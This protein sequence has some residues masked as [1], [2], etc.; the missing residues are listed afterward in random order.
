MRRILGVACVGAATVAAVLCAFGSGLRPNV[1]GEPL[2]LGRLYTLTVDLSE[3][4]FGR[5]WSLSD[6][7]AAAGTGVTQAWATSKGQGAV[8]AVIDTGIVP[9]PDIMGNLLPGYDF[10]SNRVIAND[11]DG[12]D[13]DPSD[14]GDWVSQVESTSLF[15]GACQ[16]S[17]SSW[18]G[19]HVAGIVAA[20]DDNGFGVAGVAPRAKVLPIRAI[21]KCGASEPD[22]LAAITWAS[23]GHVP[24][25]P[26]NP[27][28]ADIINLSLGQASVCKPATQAVITAAISRGSAVVVA[29]GNSGSPVEQSSPAN[30][31]GVLSVGALSRSGALAMYSNYASSPNL[32]FIVAPGGEGSG[33]GGIFSTIN[34]GTTVPVAADFGYMAG[35]SM[36]APHVSGL[37]AILKG[38]SP[39]LRGAQLIVELGKFLK[40]N[41]S[42]SCALF[43]CGAGQPNLASISQLSS[44][45]IGLPTVKRFQERLSLEWPVLPQ[46]LIGERV[47]VQVKQSGGSWGASRL[48]TLPKAD[49]TGLSSEILYTVRVRVIISGNAGPWRELPYEYRLGSR[50][51]APTLVQAVAKD[52]ALSIS[53]SEEKADL[54]VVRIGYLV[55]AT[56]KRNAVSRT[57]STVNLTCEITH[58]T[59]G[60][61]YAV[62][63]KAVTTDGYTA[64]S[65]PIVAIPYTV[66]DRPRRVSISRSLRSAIVTWLPPASDGGSAIVGYVASAIGPDGSQE[67]CETTTQ[68]CHLVT[69]KNGQQADITVN[70][71]NRA[72][73]SPI[74]QLQNAVV[75]PL[76]TTELAFVSGPSVTRVGKQGTRFL[77]WSPKVPDMLF[78]D[79]SIRGHYFC[80]G[81]WVPFGSRK[82]STRRIENVA[83]SPTKVRYIMSDGVTILSPI[84]KDVGLASK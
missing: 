45:D 12:R 39:E 77:A 60:A 54:S 36:A 52:Q 83:C 17:S 62:S 8:V 40:A 27:H 50:A 32:S 41:T 84:V 73:L 81:R 53:W 61:E 11:G 49:I 69:F 82:L 55:T 43:R 9:H 13:S 51:P 57:C 29:A 47:E 65:T 22:I 15:G 21:G 64:V 58:L 38:A 66:P 30:C 70:A 48:F 28:P 6:S 20:Q 23:G 74:E 5:Q 4:L 46:R 7:S 35:T 71:I 1:G 80:Q 79:I 18:H 25:V 33:E 37:L 67:K 76:A 14:P 2:N 78:A 56:S 34:S 59:N 26:D 16:P 10:I 31:P 75:G 3:P 72:G 63:V 68:S 24:G 19:T 44:L 42:S